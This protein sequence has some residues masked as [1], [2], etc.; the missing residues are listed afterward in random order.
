[1]NQA[2]K[3][4][5]NDIALTMISLKQKGLLT[6]P[7]VQNKD[8]NGRLNGHLV[9]A[10]SSFIETL[11]ANLSPKT[12]VPTDTAEEL[13]LWQ[14]LQLLELLGARS[15][16]L[17]RQL[18]NLLLAILKNGNPHPDIIGLLLSAVAENESP[19]SMDNILELLASQ[20]EPLCST[21]AFLDG[22]E[23][24]IHKLSTYEI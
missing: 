14:D 2:T 4:E 12:I 5:F 15:E 19:D 17:P 3:E 20:L 21:I 22:L 24:F 13:A 11:F 10:Q 8:E 6:P 9:K 1:V 23:R 16:S 18:N 7:T